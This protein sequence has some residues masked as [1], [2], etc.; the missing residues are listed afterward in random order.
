MIT[1]G[2][3]S[4]AMTLHLTQISPQVASDAHALLLCDGAGWHP[5][6]KEPRVPDN[7]PL[8]S[9]PPCTPEP[10]PMENVWQYLR[11]NKLRA[12]VRDTDD[13]SVEACKQAWHFLINDPS[14]IRSIGTRDRARVNVKR[15]G[16][17]PAR[18]ASSKLA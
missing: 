4:E 12:R 6:G 8:L 3:N 7:I 15:V 5:R 13:D 11:Q 1:P 14:R 18:G 10:N 2:A 9:L 16:I 17:S